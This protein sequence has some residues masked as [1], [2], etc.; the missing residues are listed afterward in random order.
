MHISLSVQPIL[1][2]LQDWQVLRN[3]GVSIVHN[4]STQNTQNFSTHT[5]LLADTVVISI[6]SVQSRNLLM[7][8][9]GPGMISL[10]FTQPL[11]HLRPVGVP[12]MEG[13]WASHL[14]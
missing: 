4:Q 3:L 7:C 14:L 11:L 8:K 1:N 13:G 12:S 10:L 2:V 6:E 9:V 5:S